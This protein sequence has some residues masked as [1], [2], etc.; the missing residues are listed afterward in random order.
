MKKILF[1]FLLILVI[2]SM[3]YG[4]TYYSQGSFAPELIASWNDIRTGGGNSPL[5][6]TSGDVFVVQNGHSMSSGANWS[7]S[8][9]GSKLWIENGG[10]LTA[11]FPVTLA[12]A[13]TF[14]IDDGGTFVHNNSGAPSSTIFNGIEQFSAN[15]TYWIKNWI[16]NL[17]VIPF[18]ITWGNL[19]IDVPA[20]SGSWNQVGNVATVNGTLDIRQTGGNENEFRLCSRT[21]MTYTFNIANISVSGGILN[22]QG[23]GTTGLPTMNTIVSGD[24][25]MTGGKLDM[26]TNGM[27]TV[28]IKGNLTVSGTGT[29]ISS[30]TTSKIIFDKSGIQTV[31]LTAGAMSTTLISAD[32]NAGSTV[33][34]NS[35]WV[36]SP[37]ATMNIY[38]SL[39]TNSY[40][41]KPRALNVGG[42]L[43][44][45]TGVLEQTGT[46]A[47]IVGG[48]SL[49]NT[50]T[51]ICNGVINMSASSFAS[52]L[53]QP[54]GVVNL[55]NGTINMNHNLATFFID[56]GGTLNCGTGK[57]ASINSTSS[58][59][60][61]NAGGTLAIG[62]PE[63][64]SL[65]DATGNIQVGGARNYHFAAYYCYDGT[66]AQ[67]TGNG[68]PSTV[69]NLTISNE[70]GVSLT[71][72]VLVADTLNLFA[73][74][75]LSGGKILS[76]GENGFLEYNGACYS[77]TTDV[78]FPATNGPAS[79]TINNCAPSGI[80]LH[81]NRTLNG[82][83]TIAD[84]K[85]FVIPVG[86]SLT[87]NGT[88]TLNGNECLD[89]MSDG[90]FI[91]NGTPS[92]GTGTAI[93]ERY[94][95]ANAWHYISSPVQS[96]LT[97]SFIGDYIKPYAEG[98][99]AFG[100][101]IVSPSATLNPVQGYALWPTTNQTVYFSGG[102]LNTG[103]LETGVSRTYTGQT[104]NDEY[105]GWNLVGNPYPCVVD[106]DLVH[107]IW[108]SVEETAYFWDPSL[109]VSG[110][111][112]VY[113]ARNG[114]GTHSQYV[115]AMQGFFVRCNAVASHQTPGLGTIRFNNASKVHSSEIFLKGTNQISNTLF[116]KVT[117][118]A[119]AFSDELVVCFN[120]S[121]SAGYDPGYDAYKLWGLKEAP[122]IYTIIDNDVCL[123]VN[124][125]PFDKANVVVPM[126]FKTEIPGKYELVIDSIGTFGEE[127]SI[128]LEDLKLQKTQDMKSIPEY[129]FNYE[130][131]D[132]PARF[133]LRFN[134]SKLG[135]AA[136]E[137]LQPL[138]ICAYDADIF[139]YNFSG[140]NVN[141][142][143]LLYDIAGRELYHYILKNER[144]V[145]V[146][147]WDYSLIRKCICVTFRSGHA[148]GGFTW[149]EDDILR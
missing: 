47:I 3:I 70:A 118:S 114:F 45:G 9:S 106:L 69:N 93:V 124:A 27:S 44:L 98:T 49:G 139:V 100:P 136:V 68:L 21:G 148:S 19:I 54:G 52:F 102:K 103:S 119:N 72:D 113:P 14:Q 89:I 12:K 129:E 149:L 67:V 46:A 132:L 23:G 137:K 140:K 20:L 90:S 104:G 1:V 73:G 126:G 22:I 41:F 62:S 135:V 55:N 59:F 141:G 66:T 116:I 85:K 112:S 105:D 65:A 101:Y 121:T 5:N 110:N 134:N 57:V 79:L 60:I 81:A 77:V 25:T 95:A 15:S 84:T 147:V 30:G 91:D 48:P 143:V 32:I 76:Y 96:C 56:T 36:M 133:L 37:L 115:P 130:E 88:I 4:T 11:N 17:Y 64:I 138:K 51:I 29:M 24:L 7:I 18:G 99:L 120:P 86:I 145:F 127:V 63:G 111:Y 8:G 144:G 117:G 50:G 13:T 94:I 6:F 58:T 28:S 39:N 108:D 26:G 109:S 61:L 82:S 2:R 33:S 16:G 122:Q 34:M 128:I 78:E 74:P 142:T 75:I 31:C 43:N 80:S 107:D 83:L 92:D 97:A 38:G 125:L 87:V 53:I 42:V 123:T 10:I 35:L 40:T 146:L 71:S 131:N